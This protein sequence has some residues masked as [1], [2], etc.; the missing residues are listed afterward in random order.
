LV[1]LGTS[2]RHGANTQSCYFRLVFGWIAGRL[3]RLRSSAD[4][5]FVGCRRS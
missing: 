2:A 3:M 4:V 5:S 1:A